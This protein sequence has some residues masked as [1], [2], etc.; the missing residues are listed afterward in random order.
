VRE[1]FQPSCLR[2]S[3]KSGS[4]TLMVRAGFAAR[5][6][7]PFRCVSGSMNTEQYEEVLADDIFDYIVANYGAPDAAWLQEDVAPCHPSKRS[8]APDVSVGLKPL[9]LVKQVPDL[10]PIE[11]V[12]N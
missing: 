4:Q 2:P 5:G 1:R 9:S 10:H 12:W 11:N 3:F 7:T 8:E 6:R